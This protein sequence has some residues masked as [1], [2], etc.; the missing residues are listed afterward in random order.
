MQ[1]LQ[2][3]KQTGHMRAGVS[4]L[5]SKW[6]KLHD[7]HLWLLPVVS[8]DRR[9]IPRFTD[10]GEVV[11][12][13]IDGDPDL[14]LLLDSFFEL[15]SSYDGAEVVIATEQAYTDFFRLVRK[16]L[17]TNYELTGDQ[18]TKLLT[19]DHEQ[20]KTLLN[21]VLSHVTKN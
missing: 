9:Y 4:E 20:L 15:I 17:V 1:P 11:L 7:G 10:S 14:K 6:V 16:L 3:A 5:T 12:D 19:V 13:V 18:L 21:A 8:R 2:A